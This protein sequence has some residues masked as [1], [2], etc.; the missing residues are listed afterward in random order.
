MGEF[1]SKLEEIMPAEELVFKPMP[2]FGKYREIMPDEAVAHPAKFNVCLVEF[3][4]NKYSREGDTI[5]DP[6]AGTGIL[7]VIAAL[8][9]RNAVQVEVE[10]R[11]YDWMEKAR[12]NV[13]KLPTLTHKGWIRNILGDSR[14]LA[15]LLEQADVIITSPPYTNQAAE[16]LNVSRYRKGGAFAEEKLAD[17]AMASPPDSDT[18]PGSGESGKYREWPVR[19]DVVITSPPYA[20]SKK[21]GEA[22]GGKMA[23]RWDRAFREVGERWNSWGKTWKTE[24]RVRA[25]KALGSGYSTDSGNIGNLESGEDE[26]EALTKGSALP[27][28]KKE[29]YLEA[30][31]RVYGQMYQVLKPGGR[32]IIVVKPFIRRKKVIDLPYYTL[33]LLQRCGFTLEKLYKMRVMN[34]SFWR[35]IYSRKHPEVQE[36][37]HEYVIIVRKPDSSA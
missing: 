5:L 32:A 28:K 11:F 7:G 8:H 26:Y 33:L 10:P 31:L 1:T 20:D 2:A 34:K 27:R 18:Y 25:L 17:L 24:G 22:D 15:Q 36:I 21:G 4:V 23:E 35:I 14:S 3:L 6:M 13:E 30:M 16:N 29:T 9:G 12:E 37:A 19:V